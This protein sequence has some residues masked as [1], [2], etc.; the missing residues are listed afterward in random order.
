MQE[1]EPG[2]RGAS[3][4]EPTTS[5]P[6][7]PESQRLTR[8]H[9]ATLTGSIL[10]GCA[11]QPAF[12]TSV[13]AVARGGADVVEAVRTALMQYSLSEL[14]LLEEV[15]SGGQLAP[16]EEAA[17]QQVR[18]PRPRACRGLHHDAS[19]YGDHARPFTTQ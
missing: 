7:S 2:M 15:L 4:N 14:G 11:A 8:H 18:Y 13:V 10:T 19:I 9:P 6:A 12:S 5:L 1:H 16:Q 17:V 3:G